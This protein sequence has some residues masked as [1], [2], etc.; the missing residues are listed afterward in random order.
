MTYLSSRVALV[1]CLFVPV[2]RIHSSIDYFVIS[3]HSY[4]VKGKGPTLMDLPDR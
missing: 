4:N 2:P 1:T 3:S